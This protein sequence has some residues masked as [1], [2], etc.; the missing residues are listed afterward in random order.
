M[1][2][3]RA[4]SPLWLPACEEAVRLAA[5]ERTLLFCVAGGIDWQDALGVTD[6]TVTAIVLRGLVERD[7]VGRLSLSGEGRATVAVLLKAD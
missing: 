5:A 6:D 1:R 4:E 7:A 2:N 3:L